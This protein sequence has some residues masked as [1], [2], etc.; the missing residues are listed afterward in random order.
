LV[1]SAC[2]S[3]AHLAGALGKPVWILLAYHA[4]WRWLEEREDSP[5]YPHTRL[6][7]QRSPGDWSELAARTKQSLEEWS[8][9][10]SNEP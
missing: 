2:T 10:K 3:V 8:M 9:K 4:D 5:W 7:R 6:F 1:I